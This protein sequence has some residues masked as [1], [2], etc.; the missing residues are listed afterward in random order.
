MMKAADFWSLDH[1]SERRRLDWS[2]E[3]RIFFERQMCAALFVVF[4]IVFQDPAQPG[5]MEDDDVIQALSTNRSDQSLNVGVLP[6]AL[7][8]SQNFPNVHPFRCLAEFLPIRAVAVAQQIPRGVEVSHATL[9]PLAPP[10]KAVGH[11]SQIEPW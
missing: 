4:E 10:E 2:A 3:R 7:R 9:G 5:L 11:E 8:C 6:R 1:L